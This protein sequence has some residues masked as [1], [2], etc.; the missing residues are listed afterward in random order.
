MTEQLNPTEQRAILSEF[1]V[2]P[3]FNLLLERLAK[4][5]NDYVYDLKCLKRKSAQSIKFLVF[6]SLQLEDL[7]HFFFLISKES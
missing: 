2:F 7:V 1:T 6:F 5:I 4:L 3:S